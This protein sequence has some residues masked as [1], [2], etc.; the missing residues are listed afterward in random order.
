[1]LQLPDIFTFWETAAAL[2]KRMTDFAAHN[3][4]LHASLE[5]IR[6]L[7]IAARLAPNERDA[8]IMQ[9]TQ[10]LATVADITG[11]EAARKLADFS[12]KFA[13]QA[14]ITGPG[15]FE[16]LAHNLFAMHRFLD[17]IA[18][19]DQFGNISLHKDENIQ[20]GLGLDLHDGTLLQ[21]FTDLI[22]KDPNAPYDMLQR[23]FSDDADQLIRAVQE[24]QA[25]LEAFLRSQLI[26][27]Y[28]PI[29]SRKTFTF[30]QNFLAHFQNLATEP[31][32]R[33]TQ[34]SLLAGK[35]FTSAKTH[36]LNSGI[37]SLRGFAMLFDLHALAS[38]SILSNIDPAAPETNKCLSLADAVISRMHGHVA[39]HWQNRL[40][41]VFQGSGTVDGRIYDE[42]RYLG[43]HAED[44]S[45]ETPLL[46]F[47]DDNI[48][49]EP[50][51]GHAYIVCPGDR[52]TTLTDNAYK[53]LADYR[54]VLRQNPHIRHPETLRPGTR[55]FFPKLA[56]NQE[57]ASDQA[58]QEHNAF[59]SESSESLFFA[60]R[61]ITDLKVLTRGQIDALCKALD[62]IRLSQI[63]QT[64]CVR[65]RNHIAIVC[66]QET[67]LIVTKENAERIGS[68]SPD[69]A[70]YRWACA[71]AAQLRGDVMLTDD[72]FLPLASMPSQPHRSA[73]CAS[74]LH[75]LLADPGACPPKLILHPSA[76]AVDILD[77]Y[78][79]FIMRLEHDDFLAI[80]QQPGRRLADYIAPPIIQMEMLS[81]LWISELLS[82]DTEIVVPPI[83]HANLYAST[84]H[85][86]ETH[87]LIPAGTPVYPIL[88]GTIHKIQPATP[89]C[90]QIFIRHPHGLVARYASLMPPFVSE[91]QSV[92]Q[93][94]VISF[95]ASPGAESVSTVKLEL[96]QNP[97]PDCDT[98]D[99]E[100]V[101]YLNIVNQLWPLHAGCDSLMGE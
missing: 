49:P 89:D 72:I 40:E 75:R 77:A 59:Y 63:A 34:I 74:S 96:K 53:G 69:N 95:A 57:A 46:Q 13:A 36:A 66:Q 43:L 17:G 26:L 45:W 71:L 56:Q 99:G 83:S 38:D 98:F 24:G 15:K 100:Q 55:L 10:P 7:C 93:Q 33:D 42:T 61:E 22:K 11:D 8:M 81:Q 19:A 54:F 101:A 73:W 12:R 91:G 78:N 9:L 41:S 70:L 14:P 97:S 51:P 3:E 64:Q 86:N 62:R 30:P 16:T 18:G 48:S 1:M 28:D 92:T 58:P 29:L 5:T 65:I 52:L 31:T 50:S 47:K 85:R 68:T 76:R 60:N 82:L 79:A 88:P 23:A 90:F 84:S 2:E 94:T 39:E 35:R 4:Q 21:F 6:N 32:A 87:F 37:R 67:L 25:S 27:R 44:Q 20:Y 80:R